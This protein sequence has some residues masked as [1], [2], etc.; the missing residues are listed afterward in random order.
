MQL[1]LKSGCT[2]GEAA[3]KGEYYK[4]RRKK[5]EREETRIQKMAEGPMT[6]GDGVEIEGGKGKR[7]GG[8]S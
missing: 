2:K 7:Y 5:K 1:L 8:S 6:A 4:G 3:T